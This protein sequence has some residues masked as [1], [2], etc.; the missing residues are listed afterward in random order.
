VIGPVAGDAPGIGQVDH[1]T[2]QRRVASQRI[3]L[4]R[5][6]EF[7]KG[8]LNAVVLGQLKTQMAVARAGGQD[9]RARLLNEIKGAISRSAR[10]RSA[11]AAR[12]R[13]ASSML[14]I[15]ASTVLRTSEGFAL[16]GRVAKQPGAL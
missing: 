14:A 7:G 16:R 1:F 5:K 11:R 8:K 12:S 2:M 13:C 3:F 15:A 6:F 4:Q 9:I 10:A